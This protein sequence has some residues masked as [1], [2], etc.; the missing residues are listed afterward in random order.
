MGILK[1]E[2]V[3]WEPEVLLPAAAY[4]DFQGFSDKQQLFL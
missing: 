4:L 2:Q 1:H 3:P